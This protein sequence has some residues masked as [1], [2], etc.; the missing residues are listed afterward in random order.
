MALVQGAQK[1]E[2]GEKEG[3]AA[4][5][6]QLASDGGVGGTWGRL[7]YLPNKAADLSSRGRGGEK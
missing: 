4:N 6:A 7:G 1:Q 5:T 2:D 3:P